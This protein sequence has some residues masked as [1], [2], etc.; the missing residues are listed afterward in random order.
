LG[1]AS[2]LYNAALHTVGLAAVKVLQSRGGEDPLFRAGRFGSYSLDRPNPDQPTLWFHAASVG[3]VTGAI[4]TIQEA[5]KAY[6]D[7]RLVLSVGTLMGYRSACSRVPHG[8]VVVAF[9]LDFPFALRRALESLRP[10]LFVSFESE[11]WPN[12]F[13]LLQERSIPAILLNGRLSERS[14]KRYRALRPIFGP[15]FSHF[16]WLAM[17][18]EADRRHVLAMGVS[19]S[20]V[21]VLGTSKYD[22]LFNRVNL[23]ALEP[24]RRVL[25]I[26]SGAPVLVGGSLRRSECIGL[27]RIFRELASIEPGMIGV[28][29]PRHLEQVPNMVRWL[30]EQAVPFHLLSRLEREEETRSASVVLVDRIGILFDLYGLGDLVFCGGTL[31]PIGGHNILE[32]AA[33]GKAVFYGPNVQK[34]RDEHRALEERG[35]GFLVRDEQDLLS[36]WKVWLS[37]LEGLRIKGQGGKEA[38]RALCG[39][40]AR[41]MKLIDEMLTESTV[42]KGSHGACPDNPVD[43][44]MAGMPVND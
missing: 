3:E 5:F 23:D 31:E 28:F 12:L 24:W 25:A 37:D 15:V 33:W 14:L 22:G 42:S 39:V 10:S 34:V 32:P 2:F 16:R 20:R 8:V 19:E 13:R 36:Q 30:E 43:A 6:P 26:P 29:V 11:F 4:P 7:A 40:A 9:P 1:I 41:Q 27:L 21:I 38:V 17:N 18:T 35:A 44:G